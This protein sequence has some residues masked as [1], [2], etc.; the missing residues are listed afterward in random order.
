[1]QNEPQKTKLIGTTRKD[2]KMYEKTIL[3]GHLGKD[4]VLRYTPK[5]TAVCDFS[6]ATSDG[7]TTKWWTVTTWNDL[8]ENTSQFLRKGSKVFVEGTL[9]ADEKGNPVMFQRK[10]G[11][12]GTKFELTAWVVRFLD[13][14]EDRVEKSPEVP[15]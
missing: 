1:M 3:I 9:K 14:K 10:D 6:L 8:A 12:S 2:I 5:G 13:S 11:T 7:K 15:F 4:P